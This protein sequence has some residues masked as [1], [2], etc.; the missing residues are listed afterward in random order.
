MIKWSDDVRG[1]LATRIMC[2]GVLGVEARGCGC[3]LRA[4]AGTRSLFLPLYFCVELTFSVINAKKCFHR[5]FSPEAFS[6]GVLFALLAQGEFPGVEL[7][8]LGAS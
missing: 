1:S 5:V 6:P 3:C 7:L 2:T 8:D 4:G